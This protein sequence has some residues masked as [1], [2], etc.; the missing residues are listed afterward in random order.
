MPYCYVL[1]CADGTFFA[2]CAFKLKEEVFKHLAG[3]G[4]PYTRERRPLTLVHAEHHEG[5][6]QAMRR[7]ETIK[8]WS[9]AKLEAFMRGKERRKAG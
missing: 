3:Y 2:G 7:A 5:I 9:P 4:A 6:L 1:R 8:S